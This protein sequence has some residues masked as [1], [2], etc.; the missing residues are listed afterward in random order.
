MVSRKSGNEVSLPRG[1]ALL[2]ASELGLVAGGG[3]YYDLFFWLGLHLGVAEA[4]REELLFNG[5]GEE[6][7]F[8]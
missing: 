8:L 1:A 2:S 5:N 4:G 3:V 7:L 6:Y